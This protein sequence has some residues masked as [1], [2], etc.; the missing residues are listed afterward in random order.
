MSNTKPTSKRRNGA[1]LFSLFLLTVF[2]VSLSSHAAE[3][4]LANRMYSSRRAHDVGDLITIV[5]NEGSNL[6]KSQSM[7]TSKEANA[8][9]SKPEIGTGNDTLDEKLGN[10][11]PTSLSG[12]S[13]FDGSGSK[14]ASSSFTTEFTARVIDVLP[15]RT[16]VIEGNREVMLDGEQVR[17]TMGGVVRPRDV[18]SENKVQSSRIADAQI[19]YESEGDLANGTSPGWFWRLFQWVNPF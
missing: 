9:I 17:M 11:T 18:T 16:L 4:S 1:T 5:I 2:C 19:R 12:S 7:N 8:E 6:S 15:N 14:S 10:I 13:E 3:S